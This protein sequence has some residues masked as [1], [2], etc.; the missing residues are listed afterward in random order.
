MVL[1]SQVYG[2]SPQCAA[3]NYA[4]PWSDTFCEAR[5]WPMGMCPNGKGHQGVDIRPVRCRNN[6][7]EVVAVEDGTIDRVTAHTTIGLVGGQGRH[8]RY[9]HVGPATVLVRP[10]QKVRKGQVLA[11]VSNILSGIPNTTYHLHL[12]LSGN[13][14]GP[15]SRNVYLP[16]YSSLVD[17]YR[18]SVGLPS[19]VVNGDLVRDPGHEL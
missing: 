3:A 7:S 16:P 2:K 4:M 12:D 17:A 8:W 10:G 1:N 9:M 11:R 6:D 15:G 19:T 18:R 14:A 5:G 13:I